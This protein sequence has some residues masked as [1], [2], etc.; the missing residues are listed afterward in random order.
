MLALAGLSYVLSSD[1]A[2]YLLGRLGGLG[3]GDNGAAAD[4]LGGKGEHFD[5]DN[6]VDSR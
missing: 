2:S 6:E 4:R 1:E 3:V 5:K